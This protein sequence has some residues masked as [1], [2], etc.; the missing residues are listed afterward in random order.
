MQKKIYLKLVQA[1]RDGAFEY[2]EL[3][4]AVYLAVL[5]HFTITK[6]FECVYQSRLIKPS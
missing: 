6:I 3:V 2:D 1:H 4:L 5:Y